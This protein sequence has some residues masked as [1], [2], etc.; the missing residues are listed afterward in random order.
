MIESN[1]LRLHVVRPVI[2]HLGVWS[3]DAEELIMGTIAQE[4]AMGQYLVQLGSGPALGVCQMEPA[5]HNDIWNNFL[6]YRSHIVT[7][8]NDISV[9]RTPE[10]MVWNLYYSVAM[11]RVHYLRVP[12]KIPSNLEGW[13]RY[14]KKFYN[15]ELGKAT[16]QEFIENYQ[17]YVR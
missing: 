8:I 4:S 12:E 6:R 2:Q 13:A 11:C 1:H 14:Y 5:T 17:R 9:D 3:K 7:Y 10:E 15:T 16:E